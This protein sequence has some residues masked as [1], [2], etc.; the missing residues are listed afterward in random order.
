LSNVPQLCNLGFTIQFAAPIAPER[1]RALTADGSYFRVFHVSP[2]EGTEMQLD[3]FPCEIPLFDTARAYRL[4]GTGRAFRWARVVSISSK[5]PVVVAGGLD[6]SN[7]ADCIREVRPFGV[8]VRSGIESD[9]KKS[10]SKMRAFVRA[11]RS[12]DAAT[13]ES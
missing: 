12:A 8:D 4:G 1:A 9:G 11:V 6:G 5:R 7:V 13:H 3:V 10:A 2:A